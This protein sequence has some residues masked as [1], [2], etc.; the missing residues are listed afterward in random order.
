M[1]LTRCA[2]LISSCPDLQWLNEE[3]PEVSKDSSLEV[4]PEVVLVTEV[5]V[6]ASHQEVVVVSA[7]EVVVEALHQE[8]V[9][10]SVETVVVV[11]VS[12][13]EVV[14]ELPR[15]DC[16]ITVSVK[17]EKLTPR[18]YKHDFTKTDDSKSL[19]HS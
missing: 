11:E 4:P 1:T 7:T 2:Q 18:L 15:R 16:R 14:T 19:N 3:E 12:H 5:V 13:P 9:A 17:A 10:D 6:E 8:A